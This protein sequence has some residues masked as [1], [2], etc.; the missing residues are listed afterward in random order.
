MFKVETPLKAI[1]ICFKNFFALNLKYPVQSDHIWEFIQNFFYD[2][3]LKQD[4]K[5]Q[6][7]DNIISDFKLISN[8]T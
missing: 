7:V 4:K 5:Y 2:I 8:C 3:T 6:F 1:N